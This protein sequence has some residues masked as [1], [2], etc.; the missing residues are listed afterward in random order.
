MRGWGIS[1]T[2][3]VLVGCSGDPTVEV[4]PGPIAQQ[5]VARAVVVPREGVAQVRPPVAGEVI[6]VAA[7]AGDRV[8]R[9]QE[10]A[11]IDAGRREV[12]IEAP[13]DGVV[14]ERRVSVGD[15]L[16][17]LDPPV[18][19]IADPSQIE[20]RFE[21]PEPSAAR[22]SV[23]D[24]VQVTPRGGGTVL[25][26]G[27]VER[28]SPRMEPAQIG[29]SPM[30]AGAASARPGWLP[31]PPGP[32][33]TLG[34]ELEAVIEL[35]PHQAEARVPRASITVRDGRALV[36]RPRGPFDDAVE[37]EVGRADRR[38]VEVEGLEPGTRV[39]VHGRG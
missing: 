38:H 12:A 23:G 9:G 26:E 25:A 28:L 17:P 2:V 31:L 6:A 32:S 21:L 1:A 8:E 30:S 20:L 5:V 18:F 3:L 35:P 36:H 10:L 37:V 7:S 39:R 14:L 34:R 15:D 33:F 29:Q 22:V 13:V 27:R 24:P 19:A 11:R 4:T 16:R